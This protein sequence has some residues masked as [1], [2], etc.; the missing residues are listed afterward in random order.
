M[1]QAA[2]ASLTI[3]PAGSP[4]A[5]L[6]AALHAPAFP[7]E[8][9]D[10]TALARLLALPGVFAR[11]ALAGD[12]PVGFVL[13]RVAVDEAEILTLAVLPGRRRRGAGRA[14]VT[15]VAAAARAAGGTRLYLEVAAD[16][17]AALALYRGQGFAEVGRRR[18]YY[19]RA[20]AAPVD[21]LVLARP[22]G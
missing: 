4:H 21:A 19:V 17:A 5:A 18:G 7:P 6:L 13:A 15:A 10:E 9:W 14:L 11:L 8:P 3:V 20:G 1:S 12:E 16:N 2:S 22:L